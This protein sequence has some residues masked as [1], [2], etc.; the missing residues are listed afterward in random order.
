MFCFALYSTLRTTFE[1]GVIEEIDVLTETKQCIGPSK[2][3]ITEESF[4][5]TLNLTT[6]AYNQL[7]DYILAGDYAISDFVIEDEWPCGIVFSGFYLVPYDIREDL[8]TP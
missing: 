4:V 5:N 2:D 8:L 1:Q 7:A 6:Y 3:F